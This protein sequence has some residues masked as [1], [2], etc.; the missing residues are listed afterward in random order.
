MGR[1]KPCFC[2]A[3]ELKAARQKL[4]AH[5]SRHRPQATEEGGVHRRGRCA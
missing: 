5:L 2:E 1:G 4:T 3:P